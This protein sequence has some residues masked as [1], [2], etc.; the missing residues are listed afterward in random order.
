[1]GTVLYAQDLVGATQALLDGGFGEEEAPTRSPRT[2]ARVITGE[3]I[4]ALRVPLDPF[5]Y[6]APGAAPLADSLRSR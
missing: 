4:A 2:W 5:G 6:R 3:V 1:L